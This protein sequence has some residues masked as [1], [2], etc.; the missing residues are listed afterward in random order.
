MNMV[1]A[2]IAMLGVGVGGA[3][4]YTTLSQDGSSESTKYKPSKI[5][6]QCDKDY[7]QSAR[8]LGF[9]AAKSD[10][11]CFDQKLQLLT[12]AQQKVAYKALEDRLT[13]AFM[14]KAGVKVDGH[15]V[16]FNDKR[17]G[18]VSADLNIETRG[19]VIMDQCS[20]F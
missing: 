19:S 18:E 5:Y 16:N 8:H 11:Q 1:I 13:L 4:L 3:Y 17:L 9:K 12:P 20:M 15:N 14:G 6:A 10:C 7:L 2:S